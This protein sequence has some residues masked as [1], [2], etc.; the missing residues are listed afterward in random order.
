VRIVDSDL[1]QRADTK[2]NAEKRS[3][4]KIQPAVSTNTQRKRLSSPNETQDQ[5]R[6]REGRNRKHVDVEVV[7][8]GKRKA[9][10]VSSIALLG[11]GAAIGSSVNERILGREMA[12]T[13]VNR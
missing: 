13:N 2:P 5:L 1:I 11:L 6:A 8:K 12:L 3:H 9:V 7:T 4:T 10:P